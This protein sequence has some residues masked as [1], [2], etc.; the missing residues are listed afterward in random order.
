MVGDKQQL[1]F[2]KTITINYIKTT[3]TL[4]G[5]HMCA[6]AISI[7]ERVHNAV[8]YTVLV[9]CIAEVVCVVYSLTLLVIHY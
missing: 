2:L 1:P 8:V 6:Y 3:L 5:V 4:L 7:S 9:K